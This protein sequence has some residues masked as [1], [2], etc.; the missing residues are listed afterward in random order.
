MKSITINPMQVVK[1]NY[2]GAKLNKQEEEILKAIASKLPAIN[3]YSCE[4]HLLKGSEILEWET[5]TEIDGVAIIPDKM[6]EW[7]YPV[8]TEMNHYRRLKKC[9][10]SSSDPQRRVMDYM[11]YISDIVERHEKEKAESK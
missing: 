1:D 11:K 5:V 8:I 7:S 4:K 9:W 6:Y 3:V 10:T 2:V